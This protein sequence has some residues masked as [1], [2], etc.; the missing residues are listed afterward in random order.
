MTEDSMDDRR[1]AGWF[2]AGTDGS[3]RFYDGRGWVTLE[4]PSERSATTAGPPFV[5]VPATLVV[6]GVSLAV[7]R[8]VAEHLVARG[9]S[10]VVPVVV[11][12]VV[13]YAPVVAWLAMVRKSGDDT[14]I[15]WSARRIDLLW[16]PVAWLGIVTVQVFVI[17]ILI[18]L[19]IPI[20][21]NAESVT[22]RGTGPVAAVTITVVAITIVPLVEELVF[23]GVLLA[24]LSTRVGTTA[25]VVLHAVAFGA[26]HLDPTRGWATTGTAIVLTGVGLGLGI[27]AVATRRLAAPI[28]A[29]AIF[30]GVALAVVWSGVGERVELDI[31]GG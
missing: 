18:V 19:G 9:A 25:A 12:V 22:G 26:A 30:N 31:L 8:I 24:G 16:G 11:P 17:A 3:R 13:T 27:A 5:V 23:R 21:G 15:G 29:H 2:D 10:G 14:G 7:A 28:L 4:P 6:L 20:A 1:G